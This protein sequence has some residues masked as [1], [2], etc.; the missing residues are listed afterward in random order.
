MLVLFPGSSAL[1]HEHGSHEHAWGKPGI[2]L[3]HVSDI[4]GGKGYAW[5]YPGHSQQKIIHAYMRR[6]QVLPAF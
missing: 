6:H 4:K 3:M 5:V 1:E 2:F